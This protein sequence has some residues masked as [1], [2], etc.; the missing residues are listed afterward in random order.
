MKKKRTAT[1]IVVGAATFAALALV[2]GAQEQPV[3]PRI[4]AYDKGP[5]KIDV[6]RYPEDMKARYK[7]FVVKCARCHSLARAVNS[8]F[9]FED[10]W[11]V[12]IKRVIRKAGSSI[13]FDEGKEL[14]EFLVYDSKVRKKTLY[15]KRLKEK[16]PKPGL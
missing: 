10:E 2:A 4:L 16:A 15:E 6:S 9:V 12:Y 1:L 13:S 8:D 3:D 11:E 7:V 5:A 14:F